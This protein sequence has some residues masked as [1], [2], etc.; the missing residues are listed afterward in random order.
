MLRGLAIRY[1]CAVVL[2]AHPSLTGKA[3]GSRLSGSTAW[4]ASVRS[5]LYLD[6]VTLGE[7]SNRS[8]PDRRLLKVLKANYGPIGP[9]LSHGQQR[10]S[11]HRH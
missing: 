9:V 4:D 8:D 2:L 6:R 7:N 10:G 5:R 11:I 3:T 1:Q